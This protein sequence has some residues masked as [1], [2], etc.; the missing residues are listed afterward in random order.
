MD[1][2]INKPSVMRSE[3]ILPFVEKCLPLR[4]GLMKNQRPTESGSLLVAGSGRVLRR[5]IRTTT[6]AS[7]S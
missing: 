3:E 5:R 2:E 6:L 7:T 1:F 4:A